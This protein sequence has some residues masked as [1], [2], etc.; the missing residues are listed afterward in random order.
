MF[1]FLVCQ[2]KKALAAVTVVS[3]T[4]EEEGDTDEDETESETQKQSRQC[5]AIL[6][7]GLADIDDDI[8]ATRNPRERDK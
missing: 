1:H 4:D 5:N 2:E 3:T 6:S 7:D 8:E